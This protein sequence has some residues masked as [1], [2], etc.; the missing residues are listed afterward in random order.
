MKKTLSQS[1][2]FGVAGRRRRT[3]YRPKLLGFFSSSRTT[4]IRRKAW[5]VVGGKGTLRTMPNHS[6]HIHYSKVCLN[7]VGF[8]PAASSWM[9]RRQGRVRYL[10]TASP[11]PDWGAKIWISHT[12]FMYGRKTAFEPDEG[13]SKSLLPAYN[14]KLVCFLLLCIMHRSAKLVRNIGKWKC[15]FLRRVLR[16]YSAMHEIQRRSRPL[17][18]RPSAQTQKWDD[19]N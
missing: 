9:N 3:K 14:L 1:I 5:I 18:T 2:D 12:V 19:I 11:G 16:L 7:Y 6:A 15:N 10:N 17:H 13:S 8:P 4:V